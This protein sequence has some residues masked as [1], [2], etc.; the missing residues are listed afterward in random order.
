MVPAQKCLEAAD[1]FGPQIDQRLEVKLELV[2]AIALRRSSSSCRRAC[3][4]ASISGSKK[5]QRSRPS[6]FA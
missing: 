3:I 4:S 5:R 1:A 2:S 6:L